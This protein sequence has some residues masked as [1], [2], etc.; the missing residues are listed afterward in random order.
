MLV[1]LLLF[2]NFFLTQSR[3]DFIFLGLKVLSS[4]FVFFL[5][6]GKCIGLVKNRK[7]Y[8]TVSLLLQKGVDNVWN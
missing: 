1:K 5:C 8:G 6:I 3:K 4:L 2:S 7:S